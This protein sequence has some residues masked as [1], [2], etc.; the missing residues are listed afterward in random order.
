MPIYDN[1]G[2]ANHEI[3]LIYDNNGSANS[4]IGLVY[5][6]DGTTNHLIY[7]SMPGNP[8]DGGDN[9]S[10]TGGWNFIKAQYSNSTVGYWISSTLG[11][12]ISNAGNST[13]NGILR[14]NNMID[15]SSVNTI[16]LNCSGTRTAFV[17]DSNV[18]YWGID[19]A[20]IGVSQ[21]A[22]TDAT[23]WNTIPY[24]DGYSYKPHQQTTHTFNFTIG[25]RNLGVSSLSG[26]W[27]IY[28][29]FAS[30]DCGISGTTTALE[31][32]SIKFL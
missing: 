2:T 21:T 29:I 7:S 4:Q 8:F 23:K 26:N 9:S 6:N 15:L 14:T 31:A 18:T 24:R 30:Y 17:P 32:S 3:G 25:T 13:K 16:Q 28:V 1:D 19:F 20:G 12:T 11:I 10:V 22:I 5:D 27:Y